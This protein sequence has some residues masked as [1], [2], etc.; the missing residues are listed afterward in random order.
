MYYI[1]LCAIYLIS[2][3][4]SACTVELLRKSSERLSVDFFHSNTTA[5]V[6]QGSLTLSL[7]LS[8]SL[9]VMY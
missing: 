1:Y 6:L 2:N 7:S 8:L 4:Y 9:Y 3:S 5:L